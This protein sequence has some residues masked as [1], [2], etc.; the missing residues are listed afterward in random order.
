MGKEEEGQGVV[1]WY[2]QLN[3]YFV[4]AIV[5][6]KKKPKPNQQNFMGGSLSEFA[7]L[8]NGYIQLL[9]IAI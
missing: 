9:C 8:K 1:E 3:I 4:F 5:C 2:G 6:S 7:S